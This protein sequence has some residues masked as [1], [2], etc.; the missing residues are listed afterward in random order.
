M[1]Y[2]C[3]KCQDTLF[4][5]LQFEVEGKV[6]E[7]KVKCDCMSEY[8]FTDPYDMPLLEDNVLIQKE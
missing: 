4:M 1:K 2:R 7:Y 5:T 3:N 8:R 6:I